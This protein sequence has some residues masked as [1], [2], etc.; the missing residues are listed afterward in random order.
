M[1][2]KRGNEERRTQKGGDVERGDQTRAG[3]DRKVT[4][5]V[6]TVGKHITV[7]LESDRKLVRRSLTVS[8]RN[9]FNVQ[10]SWVNT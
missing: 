10:N 4:R 8:D 3:E 6:G 2:A 9:R 1:R 7:C 5:T